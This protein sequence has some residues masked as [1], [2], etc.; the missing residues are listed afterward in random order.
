MVCMWF[1]WRKRSRI[2]WFCFSLSHKHD[3][4]IYITVFFIPIFQFQLFLPV[5]ICDE[6]N[7]SLFT[8]KSDFSYSLIF[9]RVLIIVDGAACR[10][11]HSHLNL[12][13]KKFK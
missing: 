6:L 9:F 1:W 8:F 5:F 7:F 2:F 13:W 4:S 11:S 12:S 3:F 10:A